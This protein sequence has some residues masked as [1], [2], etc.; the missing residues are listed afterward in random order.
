MRLTVD[1][2]AARWEF[3]RN[4]DGYGWSAVN[5]RDISAC[6]APP[7]KPEL[8]ACDSSL[9]EDLRQAVQ[10]SQRGRDGTRDYE[11]LDQEGRRI[12]TT[13][14]Q[15]HGYDVAED[16]ITIHDWY[17]RSHAMGPQSGPVYHVDLD[18]DD[19][20]MLRIIL[21]YKQATYVVNTGSVLGG[22]PDIRVVTEAKG[23]SFFL[24][25]D[26]LFR[27]GT[28]SI[29]SEAIAEACEPPSGSW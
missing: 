6:P 2:N 26:S 18:R 15:E 21:E 10:E 27:C 16:D 5:P 22:W 25:E 28:G 29:T 20:D 13:V 12:V 7:R 4:E 17:H 8:A 23:G 24:D 19:W 9:E 14:L 11:S 1:S 3:V